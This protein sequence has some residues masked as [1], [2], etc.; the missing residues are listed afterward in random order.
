ME[1][2]ANKK[3]LNIYLLRITKASM[4]AKVQLHMEINGA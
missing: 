2:L 3:L 1:T 4:K